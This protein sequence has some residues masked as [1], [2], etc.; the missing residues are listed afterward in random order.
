MT[1]IELL[2][3]EELFDLA[4]SEGGE[5]FP[6]EVVDRIVAGEGPINVYRIYRGMTQLELASIAGFNPVYLSQIETGNV[7]DRR[8]LWPLSPK[9]SM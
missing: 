9:L 3:D 1:T 2:S 7:P 4:K 8:R 5:S 6:I